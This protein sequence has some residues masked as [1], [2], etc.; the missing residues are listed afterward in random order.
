MILVIT[1]TT[2]VVPFTD[3]YITNLENKI[4]NSI[5]NKVRVISNLIKKRFYLRKTQEGW[6]LKNVSA[7][8]NKCIIPHTLNKLLNRVSHITCFTTEL[9]LQQNNNR[10]DYYNHAQFNRIKKLQNSKLLS[11]SHTKD[12]LKR[13]PSNH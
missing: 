12:L 8:T 9:L 13:K 4:C 7:E 11:Y 10:L 3:K 5:R 1:Y 6:N 2:S